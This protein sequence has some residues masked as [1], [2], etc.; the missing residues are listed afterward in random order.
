MLKKTVL[1]A[2]LCALSNLAHAQVAPPPQPIAEPAPNITLT[3]SEIQQIKQWIGQSAI[4]QRF[5]DGSTHA[6][7]DGTAL[8]NFLDGKVQ[9]AKQAA[10]A[11]AKKAKDDADAKSKAPPAPPPAPAQ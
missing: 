8:S 11:A 2:A 4:S 3:E 9:A 5:P 1:I 7:V 10:I 6:L